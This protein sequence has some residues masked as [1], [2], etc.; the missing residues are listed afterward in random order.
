MDSGASPLT[1]SF[2]R[3]SREV[4]GRIRI[5]DSQIDRGAT[6]IDSE[7]VGEILHGEILRVAFQ[8]FLPVEFD[9]A[10]N[11]LRHFSHDDS[12]QLVDC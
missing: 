8:A 12:I 10:V 3:E 11:Q 6:R 5:S 4:I 2:V 9:E 7:S 1:R